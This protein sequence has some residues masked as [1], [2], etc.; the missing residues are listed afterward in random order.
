MII[1][2]TLAAY[3]GGKNPHQLNSPQNSNPTDFHH[4]FKWDFSP[5][6]G[7]GSLCPH[8]C[9]P[10][11]PSQPLPAESNISHQPA[12]AKRASLGV[13]KKLIRR[14]IKKIPT[15]QTCSLGACG[16]TAQPRPYSSP[17]GGKTLLNPQIW[18]PGS[19]YLP[20]SLFAIY[21][22]PLFTTK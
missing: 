9:R 11:C 4:V 22:E 13:Q 7:S 16:R 1:T 19:L 3:L 12:P 2:E 6:A 8:L 20:P 10:S 17:P 21:N 15:S 14:I 18:W 5:R